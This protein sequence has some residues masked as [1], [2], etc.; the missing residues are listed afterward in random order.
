MNGFYALKI[1][2]NDCK[3]WQIYNILINITL[4]E[5]YTIIING[6][7][8]WRRGGAKTLPFFLRGREYVPDLQSA[9]TYTDR[10][11]VMAASD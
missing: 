10:R 8:G 5:L 4:I 7:M 1:T 11:K 2:S 6:C 9:S 3:Q